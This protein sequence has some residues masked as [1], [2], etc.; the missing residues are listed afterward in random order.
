MFGQAWF[1]LWFDPG[2]ILKDIYYQ[3]NCEREN[4]RDLKQTLV[5]DVK[6]WNLYQLQWEAIDGF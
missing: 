6:L 3:K 2:N 5:G 4:Y 1:Q